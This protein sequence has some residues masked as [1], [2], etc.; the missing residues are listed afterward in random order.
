MCVILRA[1]QAAL[2]ADPVYRPTTSVSIGRT[3]PD[4]AANTEAWMNLRC[5]LR[6]Q[7]AAILTIVLQ[8]LTP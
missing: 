3:T 6:G 4:D 2:E 5:G 8:N 1:T 7:S